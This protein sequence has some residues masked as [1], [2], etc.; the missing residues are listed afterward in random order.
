MLAGVDE[1]GILFSNGGT[2]N[3]NLFIGDNAGRVGATGTYNVALGTEA[4]DAL[5]SG[6]QNV[7]L[8]GSALGKLTTGGYSVAIGHGAATNQTTGAYNV[9][10]GHAA[11][12]LNVSGQWNVG[13]GREALFKATGYNNVGIGGAAFQN[14]T[15]G[16]GNVGLGHVVGGA[17]TTGNYNIFLGYNAG[18]KQTTNSNLLIIDNQQRADT[19]AEETNSILYGVMAAAPA[20]QALRI[21]A[22]THIMSGNVGI[23]T[24]SPSTI[25]DVTGAKNADYGFKL[26]NTG[27]T[28]SGLYVKA[29]TSNDGSLRFIHLGADNT[30]VARYMFSANGGFAL[31]N[32][33]MNTEPGAGNAIISGNV[34]VGTTAPTAKLHVVGN[35]NVDSGMI[36]IVGSQ[37]YN[38]GN[39]NRIWYQASG[40]DGLRIQ[41]S[42]AVRIR[43]YNG[44]EAVFSTSGL[45]LTGG[46]LSNTTSNGIGFS[47][48]ATTASTGGTTYGGYLQATSNQNNIAL[49]LNAQNG[50]TNYALLVDDGLV[51][52]GTTAPTHKL[53]LYDVDNVYLNIQTTGNSK[54]SGII[55]RTN[56]P[57]KQWR[58]Y[59][60]G[61]N[62]NAL[63]FYE[64]EANIKPIIIDTTGNVQLGSLATG[65]VY[66]NAGVLTNTDP[67]DA[68]LKENILD[69][70]SGTLQRLMDLRAVSFN[71][72]STG[73]GSLGFIAQEVQDIFP[74]LVG[75]NQDGTM[76]LY[77]T[78]FIPVLT[79]AIQEQQLAIEEL[80][81]T[82]Q[83]ADLAMISAQ[84]WS[85]LSA[86]VNT[87]KG[88]VDGLLAKVAS[89]ESTLTG[90]ADSF[91]TR[92]ATVET[93]C[94]GT[95]D[96][97][98]CLSKEQLDQLI[99]TLPAA[100]DLEP[101]IPDSAEPPEPSATPA[102]QPSAAVTEPT[103]EPSNSPSP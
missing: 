22:N 66:S 36:D 80:R 38:P 39:G 35:L 4:L 32:A 76:G 101:V 41:S 47:A 15:T 2:A 48:N 69:L 6:E 54:S 40:G 18:S 68:N 93:L 33:Y 21:N 26:T 99:E 97:R 28:G 17:L 20:D 5:T 8:G 82:T 102:A 72:K 87:L 31:G 95:A 62:S 75:T 25:L 59:N 11:L 71:W 60:D 64:H 13:V 78:Q 53:H 45:T 49:R 70:N 30:G 12:F 67:S 58:I 92:E 89:I 84:E 23:G 79:K 56:T 94:V 29:G 91:F 34:G 50:I 1:R 27:S 65:T 98:T 63:T 44:S 73:D 61:A 74:E 83:S 85:A 14:L 86:L 96:E 19:A 3:S 88:L 10:I 37:V 46:V 55:L 43:P 90:L 100:T 51:G 42:S 7:A 77:T 9:A 81:L 57:N 103:V 16:G 52:I 24:T